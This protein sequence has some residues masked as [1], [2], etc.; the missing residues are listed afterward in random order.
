MSDWTKHVEMPGVRTV[1]ISY[2]EFRWLRDN[3]YCEYCLEKL[4]CKHLGIKR[5]QI[6]DIDFDYHLS[7]EVYLK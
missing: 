3:G 4:A 5:E 7:F 6:D 1:V 2:E